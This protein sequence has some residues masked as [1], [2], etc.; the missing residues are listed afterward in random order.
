MRRIDT[1]AFTRATRSTSREI[2]RQIVLNLVRE[3][4][5]LSRADLARRMDVPRATVAILVNELLEEGLLVEGP[6]LDSP[7]GRKPV[8]LYVRTGDRLV[9]AADIRSGR[10]YLML[11]DLAGTPMSTESFETPATPE[12]LLD[13][14]DRRI[15]RIRASSAARGELE[16]IGVAVSGMVDR[17]GTIL[18]LPQLGWRQVPLRAALESRTGVPVQVENASNACALAH[19]WM[20]EAG[21][22]ADDFAYVNVSDGVGVGLVVGGELVRGHGYTAGEFGHVPI[23]PRGPTCLCGSVGCW[24][25]FT[26]NLATLSRYLGTEPSAEESRRLLRS[27]EVTIGDVIAR[28]RSGDERARQALEETGTY[29]ALGLSIIVN[30]LNPARIIVGGEITGAWDLIRER[31]SDA[32]RARALTEAAAGTLVVAEQM[33]EHP[34]L[35]GAVALIAAPVF[36]APEVA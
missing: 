9:I 31:V 26:S 6:V 8:M 3:Q 35:R 13:E 27:S 24:E 23:D 12:E 14:L 32:V 2:N 33:S 7:R 36:A 20:G 1:S 17:A 25:I 29:L 30:A 28:A 11:S 15:G 22:H 4:Q 16:G 18:Y 21:R 19:V 5:P 10:T 34:R